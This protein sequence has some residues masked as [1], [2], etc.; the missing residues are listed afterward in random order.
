MSS[1]VYIFLYYVYSSVLTWKTVEWEQTVDLKLISL[2]EF[3]ST[4]CNPNSESLFL[5]SVVVVCLFIYW[6]LLEWSPA[7]AASYQSNFYRMC[8]HSAC[9]LAVSCRR[10]SVYYLFNL[11]SR[12]LF[13]NSL[14]LVIGQPIHLSFSGVF[15][16]AVL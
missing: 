12:T 13:P 9:D 15:L 16:H 11:S 4:T 3:E 7:A 5:V 6:K 14:K 2:L 10:S 1:T 8:H